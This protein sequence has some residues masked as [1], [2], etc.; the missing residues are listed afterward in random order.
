MDSD[1]IRWTNIIDIKTKNWYL[2]LKSPKREVICGF[3]LLEICEYFELQLNNMAQE[4][5]KCYH[6]LIC[7]LKYIHVWIVVRKFE[8][9]YF[10]NRNSFSF[11][12]CIFLKQITSHV[13]RHFTT[14]KCSAHILYAPFVVIESKG[15][16]VSKLV[17][18]QV[19]FAFLASFLSS[20][21]ICSSIVRSE[22]RCY[23]CWYIMCVHFLCLG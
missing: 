23:C 4:N 21:Q 9:I 17:S 7:W 8:T 5:N 1:Y 10:W 22:I 15:D 2:P 19:P 11:S 6:K 13:R 20:F 3:V 18:L 12:L 16:Q 14:D